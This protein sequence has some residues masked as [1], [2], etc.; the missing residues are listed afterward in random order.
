MLSGDLK[1]NKSDSSPLKLE[2][3]EPSAKHQLI[4]SDNGDAHASASV[5]FSM[6]ESVKDP[7]ASILLDHNQET[8]DS[9]G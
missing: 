9:E 5:N 3:N 1:I 8:E 7:N 6:D 4:A 2:E